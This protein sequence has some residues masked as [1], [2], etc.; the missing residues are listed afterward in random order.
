MAFSILTAASEAA[1]ANA[2]ANPDETGHPVVG[3]VFDRNGDLVQNKRKLP[4]VMSLPVWAISDNDDGTAGLK[5]SEVPAR[6][7]SP[8]EAAHQLGT[9]VSGLK[10][11]RQK[12]DF[13]EPENITERLVG[14]P[15]S[16]IT[17][18]IANGGIEGMKKDK[19]THAKFLAKQGKKRKRT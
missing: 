5:F 8:K 4:M 9:S 18:Y 2:A 15:L 11:A 17:G 16:T 6:L 14:W 1:K 10:R 3:I 12:G 7:V 19:A 13:P